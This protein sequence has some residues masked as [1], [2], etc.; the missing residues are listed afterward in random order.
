LIQAQK[1]KVDMEATMLS[2][3]HLMRA[4]ELNFALLTLIPAS[5]L[6]YTLAAAAFG[7]I[8]DIC[9]FRKR[10][11]RCQFRDSLRR[12][13]RLINERPDDI[14]RGLFVIELFRVYQTIEALST[15]SPVPVALMED[16]NDLARRDLTMEQ[17]RWAIIR[18]RHSHLELHQ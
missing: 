2:L 17:K 14:G 8:R 9:G 1:G 12:L 5:A 13:E 18:I 4:N 6:A 7:R 10:K 3:D 11:L 15:I 16:F